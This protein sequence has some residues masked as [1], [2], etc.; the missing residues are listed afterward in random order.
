M[1]VNVT[2]GLVSTSIVLS[3]VKN[4]LYTH[5]TMAENWKFQVFMVVQN[6]TMKKGGYYQITK[7]TYQNYATSKH[8]PKMKMLGILK[9]NAFVV[10]ET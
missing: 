8:Q 4:V 3:P 1:C 10:L 2:S 6:L 5:V 7:L 9:Y